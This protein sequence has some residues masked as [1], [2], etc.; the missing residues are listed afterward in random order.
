MS[1]IFNNTIGSSTITTA[2]PT[3]TIDNSAEAQFDA[4]SSPAADTPP[5]TTSRSTDRT[6]TRTNEPTHSRTRTR[7]KLPTKQLPR[8]STRTPNRPN[9][10]S[11]DSA[12]VKFSK[13]EL[14]AAI[15]SIESTK[16]KCEKALIRL[17]SGSPQHTLTTRRIRAF[18]ISLELLRDHALIVMLS[19]EPE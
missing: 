17:P 15:S 19:E 4:Q 11:A 13:E 3:E 7:D 6:R 5:R 8:T 12:D 10:P 18:D 9:P 1:M 14:D 2:K 16:S